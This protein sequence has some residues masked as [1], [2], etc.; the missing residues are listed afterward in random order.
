MCWFKGDRIYSIKRRSR[1]N[2]TF[3]EKK[4]RNAAVTPGIHRKGNASFTIGYFEE[5]RLKPFE[6]CTINCRRDPPS[7]N[8]VTKPPVMQLKSALKA[9]FH[10]WRSRSRSRSRGR[11]RSRSRNRS[12]EQSHKRDEIV[13]G[14]IRAFPISSDFAYDSVAYDLAKTRLLESDISGRINQSQCTF[15][16]FVIGLV[17]PLLLATP[18]T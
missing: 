15:P 7:H 13:V 1:I 6:M 2:A 18:T 3:G 4:F 11:S 17:L 5:T 16:R 14:R 12:R 9:G 8:A 10:L